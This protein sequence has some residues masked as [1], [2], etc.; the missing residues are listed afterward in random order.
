MERALC[1]RRG[2]LTKW[3]AET[4]QCAVTGLLLGLVFSLSAEVVVDS[5][6]NPPS[7]PFGQLAIKALPEGKVMVAALMAAG[8]T[9]YTRLDSDGSEDGS[10]FQGNLPFGAVDVA[11][12]LAD[13]RAIIAGRSLT[14]NG[15]GYGSVVRVLADGSVDPDFTGPTAGNSPFFK[16]V[17][18]D[19]N[20]RV[21]LASPFLQNLG[22]Q[23]VQHL[24]RLSANGSIDSG[25]N[26]EPGISFSPT[27]NLF[28][29]GDLLMA[30]T[31][32]SSAEVVKI[33]Q[34]NS[35]VL[36]FG[37]STNVIAQNNSL[38]MLD[39][40]GRPIMAS[41]MIDE[42]YTFTNSVIR[43]MPNGAIDPGFSPRS[44]TSSAQPASAYE[45]L[46]IDRFGRYYLGGNFDTYD[47]LPRFRLM[48]V[49]PDGSLDES[50]VADCND[51]VTRLE[52]TAAGEVLV[53]GYFTQIN[54]APASGLARLLV[55]DLVE[56]PAFQLVNT[57]LY[58]YDSAGQ[59]S[60]TVMRVGPTNAAATVDF[61][62][63]A[64]SAVAGVDYIETAGTLNL[65]AGQDM[66][67]V[68]VTL[69]RNTSIEHARDFYFSLS[70]PSLGTSLN[71]RATAL[72]TLLESDAVVSFESPTATFAEASGVVSLHLQRTGTQSVAGLRLSAHDGTAVTN[73]NYQLQTTS[74]RFK[75]GETS[76]DVMVGIVDNPYENPDLSFLLSADAVDGAV[77]QDPSLAT[78]TIADDDV[79]EFPGLGISWAG[80]STHGPGALARDSQGRLLVAGGFTQVN[81]SP[82][83]NLVRLLPSGDVDPTFNP[84]T[85]PNDFV[86]SVAVDNLDRIIIG[87]YFTS[88]NGTP[89]GRIARLLEDGTLD[90]TFDVGTGFDNMV[91]RV[92][93]EPDGRILAG[94]FFKNCNGK[95]RLAVALLGDSG[96]VDE[97]FVPDSGIPPYSF[98]YGHGAFHSPAG[99]IVTGDPGSSGTNCLFRLFLTGQRDPSFIT[100]ISYI[101]S[102]LVTTAVVQLD[103]KI[104][105][106]GAFNAVNGVTRN[107]IARLNADGSLDE[108]FDPGV[109]TDE[110][111]FRIYGEADGKFV[112]VGFFS[113]YDGMPRPY[114]ARVNSDGSLDTTFAPGEG[115]NAST[116]AALINQDNS[117]IVGGG[118]QHFDGLNRGGLAAVN[119]DGTL[120]LTV[121]KFLSADVAGGKCNLSVN[122][123]PQVD[124]RLLQSTSLNGWSPVV[125]NRTYKRVIQFAPD[126]N[127][128]GNGFFQAERLGP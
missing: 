60:I 73:Q 99:I 7:Y 72:I 62:T 109:G 97:S 11:T 1:I 90:S 66:T 31:A 114:L 88:Y 17:Q 28:P 13:G 83:T 112:L 65:A 103:G 21:Y 70:N 23:V 67:N 102:P 6:F 50:F 92:E 110:W 26:P 77:L 105:I 108:S 32:A 113:S 116:A 15:T 128:S 39:P 35:L 48:R 63:S 45:A 43:L 89:A 30:G 40:S 33:A 91:E 47:G 68:L 121:P 74:V 24:V 119:A 57:N 80:S 93:I 125:T 9:T 107:N 124:V 8:S 19:G 117:V 69:P 22:G 81:G 49:F 4:K 41:T 95:P 55:D 25:F 52:M 126:M 27:F 82:I 51:R 10:Y 96:A 76:K 123:E 118:F 53:G 78:V 37:T 44:V 12:F 29:N 84:G 56:S 61:T 59:V 115:P 36:S 3:V 106:G 111:V 101:G 86:Y 127:A 85:G 75:E 122:V 58:E 34:D 46:T 2:G 20:D 64:G 54:G 100:S 18:V 16:M 87:G 120:A 5:T 71:T 42:R 14:I 104:V 98:Y 94:G 79:A 38:V